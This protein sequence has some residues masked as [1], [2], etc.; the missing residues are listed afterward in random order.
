MIQLSHTYMTTGETIALTIQTFVGKVMSLLFNM[1]SRRRQWQPIPVLCFSSK[2]QALL[3]FMAAVAIHCDFGA[4]E[5]KICHCFHFFLMYLPWSDGTG[6]HDPR[7]LNVE[8]KASFLTLLF[9][10][11]QGL[12]SSSLSAIRVL[13]SICISEVFDVSPGSLDSSLWFVQPSISHDVLR[14]GDNI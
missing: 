13:S 14:Q 11:H 12:F 1:L 2:E 9:L 7:F 3:N 8:F 4:Q 10:P 5:K 6:C